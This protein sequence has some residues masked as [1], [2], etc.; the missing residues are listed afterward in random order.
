MAFGQIWRPQRFLTDE[1]LYPNLQAKGRA[2]VVEHYG[3][4]ER[5][6]GDR[7]WAVG[8]AYSFV[9]AYLLV[10]FRWGNRIGLDMRAGCPGWAS[11]ADRV[12]ARPAVQRTLHREGIGIW[13]KPS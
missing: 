11:H 3:S 7:D 13:D 9:D 1:K 6:I 5:R 10:F 2:D 8:N 12:A 4:I